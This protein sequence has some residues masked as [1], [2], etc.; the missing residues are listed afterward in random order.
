MNEEIN[1]MF[2]KMSASF[3]DG[4]GKALPECP[5]MKLPEL[6]LDFK[7]KIITESDRGITAGMFSMNIMSDHPDLNG[8]FGGMTGGPFFLSSTQLLSKMVSQAIEVGI[9]QLVQQAQE[10]RKKQAQEQKKKKEKS[11]PQE[12]GKK[13]NGGKPTLH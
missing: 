4:E 13:G 1:E 11:P 10:H 3:Y 7:I 6:M 9:N 8:S 2:K 12:T 5:N